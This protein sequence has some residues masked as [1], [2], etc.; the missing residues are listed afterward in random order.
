MSLLLLF[1]EVPSVDEAKCFCISFYMH[2]ALVASTKQQILSPSIKN[3][4]QVRAVLQLLPDVDLEKVSAYY[5]TVTKDIGDQYSWSRETSSWDKLWVDTVSREHCLKTTEPKDAQRDLSGATCSALINGV[6]LTSPAIYKPFSNLTNISG[7]MKMARTCLGLSTVSFRECSLHTLLCSQRTCR[8]E[9]G[10]QH[11][12]P[13][14]RLSGGVFCQ[15]Q[16]R[17]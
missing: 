15:L 5:V 4:M 14:T 10:L 9:G 8:S 17:L 13:V 1:F 6:N 12:A 7:L 3:Y 16:A 2:Q 11:L